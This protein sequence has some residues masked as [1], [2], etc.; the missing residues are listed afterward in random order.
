[1]KRYSI[2]FFLCLALCPAFAQRPSPDQIETVKG[3]LT[4]Q[5]VLHGSI[6][7]T[8]NNKIIYVDPFGGAK[9]F[10]DLAAPD[11]ILITDIHPDH[12]NPETLNAIETGKATLVVPQAVADQLPEKLKSKAVVIANGKST[13]Q[14]GISIAAIPMYN[15][16]EA[17]D[18]KHT[19]GRGN[20]YI[21]DLGGKKIYISGDT[22]DIPEM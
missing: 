14:Q 1:M 8:W 18:S 16:P 13:E 3:K 2:L 17:P 19:K 9:A 12:L 22:E 20:G 21:L 11:L 7:L 4:I 6:V 10:K 15:L 5:P